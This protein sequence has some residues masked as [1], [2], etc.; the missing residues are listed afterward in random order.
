MSSTT[1]TITEPTP[2]QQTPTP[3]STQK[4]KIHQDVPSFICLHAQHNSLVDF[5][6][7]SELSI[8][9]EITLTRLNVSLFVFLILE[10]SFILSTHSHPFI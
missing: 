2:K 8:C 1:P 4:D 3:N 5:S 6:F 9:N 7:M 10:C